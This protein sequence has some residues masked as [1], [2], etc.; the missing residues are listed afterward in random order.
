MLSR[1]AGAVGA[2]APS[3]GVKAPPPLRI[4]L[5]LACSSSTE[6]LPGAG[7]SGPARLK[8]DGHRSSPSAGV[9]HAD[10]CSRRDRQG[11]DARCGD[12]RDGQEI[13]G[14][15]RRGR[16]PGRRR[17]P[18]G[19]PDADFEAAGATVAATAKEALQG[20][21]HRAQGAPPG[22]RRAAGCK[23]GALVIAIMDPYGQDAALQALAGGAGRRP[24]PW[25]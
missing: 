20:R 1:V 23:P 6:S 21:R 4:L 2:M 11:R 25:S 22:A 12:A 17:A 7:P 10:R 16:G 13:H 9:L 3:I 24:S 14:A 5:L 8:L 19:I 18:A 15:R